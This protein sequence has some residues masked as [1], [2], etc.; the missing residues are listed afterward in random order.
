MNLTIT[1]LRK[2]GAIRNEM[3]NRYSHN[4]TIG[5]V[6][7][8]VSTYVDYP[9]TG[10]EYQ[11][12]VRVGGQTLKVKKSSTLQEANQA[13]L[14][15]YGR[16]LH[17][18]ELADLRPRLPPPSKE[19]RISSP[20][21]VSEPS[22]SRVLSPRIVSPRSPSPER[23]YSPRKSYYSPAHTMKRRRTIYPRR[24]RRY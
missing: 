20:G 13:I 9:R 2:H 8:N 22:G 10:R 11:L 24:T 19:E 1:G 6:L 3:T 7:A 12:V 4:A 18:L 23:E 5:D 21:Y 16:H 17:R 14:D 15:N